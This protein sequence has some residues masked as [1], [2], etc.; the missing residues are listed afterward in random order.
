MV[1][2]DNLDGNLTCISI[3]TRLEFVKSCKTAI[4]L[5]AIVLSC[6][7]QDFHKFK[8]YLKNMY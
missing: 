7:E 1:E 2:I 8:I 4:L 5:E 6:C 3:E